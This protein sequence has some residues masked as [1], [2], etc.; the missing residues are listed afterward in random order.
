MRIAANHPL[1]T[2][3][4]LSKPGNDL[5]YNILNGNWWKIKWDLFTFC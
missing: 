5:T 4:N 1:Y 2:I 3:F